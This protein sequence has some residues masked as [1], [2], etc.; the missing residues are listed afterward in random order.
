MDKIFREIDD[1]GPIKE[2]IGC[3]WCCLRAPCMA[4]VRL[5]PGSDTCPALKWNGQRHTCELMELPGMVGEAYR[6]ELYAGEGCCGNMNSWRREPLKDRIKKTDLLKNPIPSLMQKFLVSLG[7]Q[8]VSKDTLV[9]AVY[10][11]CGNLIEKDGMDE[12]EAELI[13]LR[14]LELLKNSR[15]K[16]AEEFLG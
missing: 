7:N 10:G 6:K 2:C 8:M 16:M 1:I 3:G 14:C 4:S 9:L 15:N 13:G 12:G 5:Y 11:F